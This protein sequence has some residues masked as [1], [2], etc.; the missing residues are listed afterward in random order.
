MNI[1]D[2][3]DAHVDKVF[4]FFYI[5]CL[6]RSLA[7]D[8]TSKTFLALCELLKDEDRIIQDHKKFLYGIMRNHW[9][10]YLRDKYRRQEVDLEGIQ[11]FEDYVDSEIEDYSGLT[12]KQRAEVFIN[13]LPEKQRDIVSRRLLEGASIKDIALDI[14]KD[15]NYIKTTYKRGLK[16]L[17]ELIESNEP[18]L[19]AAREEVS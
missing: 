19:M 8:L 11:D 7:E 18:A 9:L 14:G 5:K 2:V 3:Y 10:M 17:K 4:K 13:K 15:S 1:E 12:I 16:R 6:D